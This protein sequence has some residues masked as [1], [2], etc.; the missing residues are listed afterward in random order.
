MASDTAKQI[1]LIALLRWQILRNS[2]RTTRAKLEA[3]AH[4][5]VAVGAAIVVLVIGLGFYAIAF[6]LV[7]AGRTGIMLGLL[8]V[9]FVAWL[10]LPV[11][12]AAASTSIEFREL[13]RYPV[14]FSA[15][16]IL[17][18]AYSLFDPI[19]LT[20]MFW[21]AC[22]GAGFATVK[23]E[24][25]LWVLPPLLALAAMTLLLSRVV[26]NFVERLFTKRRGREIFFLVFVLGM[27]GLQILG[28]G[29]ES[30]LAPAVRFLKTHP[31]ILQ[32]L[33]PNL[34]YAA[35]E[36]AI[37]GEPRS[38]LAATA[39]LLAYAGALFLFFR[40]AVLA[41]Y[42][43]EDLS[44]S[45]GSSTATSA[46]ILKGW[47][48]PLVS[49]ATA[50]LLEKEM[51]YTLRNGFM[52]MN[53]FIPLFVPLVLGLA[54]SSPSRTE[55]FFQRDPGILFFGSVAYLLL[56][57][58]HVAS[59]HFAFEGHGIQFLLLAPV[60]FRQVVAAKNLF[61]GALVVCEALAIWLMLAVLGK[62]PGAESSLVT[63]AVVPFLL[64]SQ[65][66]VGNLLSIHFPRRFDFGKFKQRQSGMSVLLGMTQQMITMGI[67]G[68]LFAVMRWLNQLW[69]AGLIYLA[70]GVAAWQAY[71][72]AF[73]H[74][75]GL[76]RRRREVL[77]A[78]LCQD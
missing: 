57:T 53:L 50:A 77:A 15:F 41:Q 58:M 68:G 4:T 10:I 24:L 6:L 39:L 78:E 44:E 22:A 16:L 62:M 45:Q 36:G 33:P 63:L 18:L 56:V 43:G 64:L 23:P 8:W 73:D 54:G 42:R 69:I 14:R 25:L 76:A 52:V 37:Q 35:I 32:A 46:T 74:Y 19:A 49:G 11:I 2:L 21:L 51:R 70:L 38:V 75:E 40:R 27:L 31:W 47:R 26:M 28:I 48:V 55:P 7:D 30:Y 59:N 65:L 9:I 20:A 3:V 17:S 67:A 61:Y 29:A 5:L 66:V 13:L 34:V 71:R 60:E 12:V 72:I 1:G